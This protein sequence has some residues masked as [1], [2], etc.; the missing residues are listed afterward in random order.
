MAS[1]EEDIKLLTEYLLSLLTEQN[2]KQLT[3]TE[4]SKSTPIEAARKTMKQ[5]NEMYGVEVD[6]INAIIKRA[7]ELKKYRKDYTTRWDKPLWEESGGLD[8]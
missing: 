7:N 3:H 1:K 6:V 8:D 4:Q 5:L 2:E